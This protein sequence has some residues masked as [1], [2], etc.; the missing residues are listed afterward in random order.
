[1]KKTESPELVE[2]LKPLTVREAQF[3][4]AMLQGSSAAAAAITAGYSTGNSRK[5]GSFLARKPVIRAAIAAGKATIATTAM[6][7]TDSAM[8]KLEENL[9]LAVA[10]KQHSAAAKFLE[11]QLKLAGLLDVKDK[12]GAGGG[13][14]SINITGLTAPAVAPL[15]IENQP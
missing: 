10:S 8:A 6:L 12:G 2:H 14:F 15:T 9:K 3:V 4:G 13:N 11:L 5:Q 7:S 1:M